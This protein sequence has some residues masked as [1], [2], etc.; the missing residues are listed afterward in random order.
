[1]RYFCLIGLLCL[2]VSSAWAQKKLVELW[3]T[4][5][6]PTP[7]SVLFSPKTNVLYVSLIDGDGK[8][9]DG[10]GGIALLNLDGSIKDKN[11][12]T[13]MDAPK[14]LAIY[15]DMLYVADITAVSI[16]DIITGNEIDRIEMPGASFLNDVTVDDNGVVYISDTFLNKIFVLRDNQPSVFMDNVPSVNGLKFIGNYLYALAGPELWKIDRAKKATVVAKGF[17]LGGDGLEPVGKGDFLVTCW[18]GLI[19][20]VHANGTFDLLL[21]AR[22]KMNTADLGFNPATNTLYIPTFNSNSVKAYRLE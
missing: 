15:K 2:S 5:D 18:G 16:I 19:Y 7:E 1:M 10:K 22:G 20:Y 14:G 3:N 9:K 6:L 4:K 12:I 17:E 8:D 13:G 21:D 11:W